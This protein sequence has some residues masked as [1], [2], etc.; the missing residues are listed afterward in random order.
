MNEADNS[1]N[2]E[3][4]LGPLASLIGAWE[5]IYGEEDDPDTAI[6]YHETI[7]FEPIGP[8]DTGAGKLHGLRSSTFAWAYGEQDG[9]P[10]HE[11][12]GYWLWCPR[13][14]RVIRSFTNHNGVAIN[15]AGECDADADQFEIV[16]R[17]DATSCGIVSIPFLNHGCRTLAYRLALT[18]KS[19]HSFS[20]QE[21]T[22]LRTEG[23][24]ETFIHRGHN[25]LAKVH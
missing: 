23:G 13:E 3:A 6:S 7:T 20:Y 19:D 9:P 10:I 18:I 4:Q 24:E 15:A 8:V 17:A 11:E 1:R 16:A 25:K 2:R 21:E 14:R 22:R 5:G 12:L